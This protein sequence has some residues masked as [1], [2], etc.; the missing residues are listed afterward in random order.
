MGGEGRGATKKK[1]MDGPWR[2]VHPAAERSVAADHDAR[3]RQARPD[4]GTL[5]LPQVLFGLRL[6]SSYGDFLVPVAPRPSVGAQLHGS[7]LG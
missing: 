3:P 7:P 2:A 1:W 6:Q 4:L 5:K